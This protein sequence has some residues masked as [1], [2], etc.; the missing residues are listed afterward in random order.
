[1]HKLKQHLAAVVSVMGGFIHA[2][3]KQQLATLG[4]CGL[5]YSFVEVSLTGIKVLFASVGTM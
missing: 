1:V 5:P 3:E 4:A 2:A